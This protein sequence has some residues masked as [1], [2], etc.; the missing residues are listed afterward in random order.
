MRM[1]VILEINGKKR[2]AGLTT[3]RF[4]MRHTSASCATIHGKIQWRGQMCACIIFS[5]TLAVRRCSIRLFS[6][7]MSLLLERILTDKNTEVRSHLI[8]VENRK[9]E[10]TNAQRET[11]SHML[12]DDIDPDDDH[13]DLENLA[14]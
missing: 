7:S 13:S 9:N 12:I 5:N 8:Y 2:R 1:S 10:F 3:S 4:T 11:I 14:I 6:Q